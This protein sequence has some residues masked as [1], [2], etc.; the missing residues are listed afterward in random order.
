MALGMMRL[1]AA[2]CAIAVAMALTAQAWA[3]SGP[4]TLRLLAWADFIA[5]GVISQF[6]R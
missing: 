2:S 6:E 3:A 4:Q 1:R 5:P